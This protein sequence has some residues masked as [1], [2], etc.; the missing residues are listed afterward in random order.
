MVKIL[1][2]IYVIIFFS[3]DNLKFSVR[4][5][6]QDIKIRTT[7]LHYNRMNET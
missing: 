4:I 1:R 3:R 7:Y 5:Y 6:T 2:N